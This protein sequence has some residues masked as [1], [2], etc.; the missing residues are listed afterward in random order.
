MSFHR[1]F[2]RGAGGGSKRSISFHLASGR[3][4]LS[5]DTRFC[6]AEGGGRG[7]EQGAAG[8]PTVSA[9]LEALGMLCSAA[10]LLPRILGRAR[11]T[12]TRTRA[13]TR[14][15]DRLRERC[16][17][18]LRNARVGV[19]TSEGATVED[20]SSINAAVTEASATE[21]HRHQSRGGAGHER[22]QG[23]GRDM[24][25]SKRASVG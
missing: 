21:R 8:N 13:S 6:A 20:A 17:A 2:S 3:S 15:M 9:S 12:R 18:I 14:K 25:A 1:A 7:G 23:H 5:G 19:V 11:M 10:L 22:R 16:S 4:N 24:D